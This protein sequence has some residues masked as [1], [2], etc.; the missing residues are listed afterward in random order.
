MKLTLLR[1]AR[2]DRVGINRLVTAIHRRRRRHG[3]SH[4]RSRHRRHASPTWNRKEIPTSDLRSRG[5]N[6][7]E[8]TSRRGHPIPSDSQD[9]RMNRWRFRT[10][11]ILV[12]VEETR[13]PTSRRSVPVVP[14][15]MIQEPLEI[16]Q[17]SR[18]ILGVSRRMRRRGR[19]MPRGRGGRMR[20][21][22]V[23]AMTMMMPISS[24]ARRRH[25]HGTRGRFPR[26]RSMR[27]WA[28]TRGSRGDL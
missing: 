20:L 25:V 11:M 13:T 3:R 9:G 22:T 28:S 15:M 6:S 21:P 4:P 18:M 19:G 5:L 8:T 26:W 17:R 2:H 14:N 1:R 16:M 23:T 10:R 7:T 27:L 12:P 24:C